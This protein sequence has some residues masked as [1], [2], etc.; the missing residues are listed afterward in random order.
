MKQFGK[1]FLTS[2][3]PGVVVAIILIWTIN[4]ADQRNAD[5]IEQNKETIAA[6][7]AGVN[8]YNRAI[9][10]AVQSVRQDNTQWDSAISNNPTVKMG[11]QEIHDRTWANTL[12]TVS[13]DVADQA[14]S[15][16]YKLAQD[17]IACIDLITQYN[18]LSLPSYIHQS[19]RRTDEC[20]GK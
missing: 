11:D 20:L 16:V 2:L 3:L 9:D 15:I 17:E 18:K 13:S 7:Q 6:A 14:N 4:V 5:V 19:I 12:P 8:S 1:D 10:S